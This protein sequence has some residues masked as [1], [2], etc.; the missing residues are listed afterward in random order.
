MK[1]WPRVV[2]GALGAIFLVLGVLLSVGARWTN[3]AA[4]VAGLLLILAGA[5][6]G[7]HALR[8]RWPIDSPRLE[9]NG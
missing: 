8:G 6:L 3:D 5:D 9:V 1:G 2:V 4:L 7:W